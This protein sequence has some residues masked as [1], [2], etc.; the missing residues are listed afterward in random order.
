[1]RIARRSVESL[2]KRRPQYEP[3]APASASLTQERGAFVTLKERGQLRGCIGY[4]S[5]I[6]AALSDGSRRGQ[7]R[8]APGTRVSTRW[9][10]RN[11]PA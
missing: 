8:R 7:V 10:R 11:W 4:V 2:S 1:M 3:P 5:P 6:S 9:R